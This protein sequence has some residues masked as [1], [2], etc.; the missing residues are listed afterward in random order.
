MLSHSFPHCISMSILLLCSSVN[1]IIHLTLRALHFVI[2]SAMFFRI[3]SK[4]LMNPAQCPKPRGPSIDGRPDKLRTFHWPFIESWD[5][6]CQRVRLYNLKEDPTESNNLAFKK[7]YR[8]IVEDLMRR[9]EEKLKTEYESGQMDPDV[10]ADGLWPLVKRFQVRLIMVFGFIL[11]V[12]GGMMLCCCWM[13]C[14]R[15]RNRLKRKQD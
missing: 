1:I 14:C 3:I 15:K 6:Q 11:T 13:C 2:N 8:P 10:S 7:E 9:L 4:R 5:E 12:S